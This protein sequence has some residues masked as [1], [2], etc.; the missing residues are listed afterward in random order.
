MSIELR[1]RANNLMLEQTQKYRAM[2]DDAIEKS[3]QRLED[4][5]IRFANNERVRI[6]MEESIM[7]QVDMIVANADRFINELNDDIKR[8]NQNIDAL[9]GKGFDNANRMLEPLAQQLGV[10]GIENPKRELL[11]NKY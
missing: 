10:S 8:L 9:T 4:I 6:R 11:T 3:T 5:Q 2:Q 1:E 7:N